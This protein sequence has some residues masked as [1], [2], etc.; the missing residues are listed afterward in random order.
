MPKPDLPWRSRLE[1][2]RSGVQETLGSNPGTRHWQAEAGRE[3][4]TGPVVLESPQQLYISSNFSTL[5]ITLILVAKGCVTSTYRQRQSPVHASHVVLLERSGHWLTSRRR[6]AGVWPRDEH[7]AGLYRRLVSCIA[8]RIY[9]LPFARTAS[10][11]SLTPQH[12]VECQALSKM[13]HPITES[14]GR[15]HVLEDMLARNM[16]R[17]FPVLIVNPQ[18]DGNWMKGKIEKGLEKCSLY[19]EQPISTL[20]EVVSIPK[21]AQFNKHAGRHALSKVD[22]LVMHEKSTSMLRNNSRASI[23][24]F[25]GPPTQVKERGRTTCKAPITGSWQVGRRHPLPPALPAL[26]SLGFSARGFVFG[27]ILHPEP[28]ISLPLVISD[29]G[30]PPPRDVLSWCDWLIRSRVS[31]TS[32]SRLA[33]QCCPRVARAD[34]RS[35]GVVI[36]QRTYIPCV[37]GRHTGTPSATLAAPYLPSPRVHQDSAPS[38]QCAGSSPVPATTRRLS[39]WAS[40]RYTLRDEKSVLQFRALRVGAKGH[41]ALVSEAGGNGRSPRRPADQRHRPAR[42]PLAKNPGVTRP[43]IKPGSLLWEASVLT[44]QPP[45]PPR[46]G[47]Y[48][49][50][51]DCHSSQCSKLVVRCIS[52]LYSPVVRCSGGVLRLCIDRCSVAPSTPGEVFDDRDRPGLKFTL[53]RSGV[54]GQIL[55]DGGAVG[56]GIFGP[57]SRLR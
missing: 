2:H 26:G 24:K 42:F 1:R 27:C 48:C 10:K 43:G 39:L 31:K 28:N 13:Q 6:L 57:E 15:L 4:V 9:W 38:S 8:I 16:F 46:M 50:H 44:A 47:R 11:G 30:A 18:D 33:L 3:I 32:V 14:S 53:T 45:R 23:R 7:R 41:K 19:R 55:L 12:H 34:Q 35:G 49:F 20:T 29:T 40:H 56:E 17:G 37:A 25:L 52:P 51:P 21:Y 36:H 54:R 5:Q 22:T